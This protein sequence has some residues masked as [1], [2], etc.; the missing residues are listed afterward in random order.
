M[1]QDEKKQNPRE[2][3]R[4]ERPENG[5]NNLNEGRRDEIHHRQDDHF[6]KGGAPNNSDYIGRPP[7]S[8]NPPTQKEEE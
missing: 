8:E 7:V 4:E 5:R 1:S 6:N 2:N 3:P